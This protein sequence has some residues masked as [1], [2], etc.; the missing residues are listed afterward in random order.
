MSMF[1]G[2]ILTPCQLAVCSSH[3]CYVLSCQSLIVADGLSYVNVT[4]TGLASHTD[5]C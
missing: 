4:H 3:M 2:D 1:S 5:Q